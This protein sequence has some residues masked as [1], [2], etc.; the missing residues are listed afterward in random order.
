MFDNPTLAYENGDEIGIFIDMSGG[1]S[2]MSIDLPLDNRLRLCYNIFRNFFQSHA[3]K[4]NSHALYR[5]QER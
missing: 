5:R 1:L 4:H 2:N 3:I